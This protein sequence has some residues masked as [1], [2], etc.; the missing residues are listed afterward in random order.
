MLL[1]LPTITAVRVETLDIANASSQPTV[2][3]GTGH[4]TAVRI[5]LDE[6]V[7]YSQEDDMLP[8]I[9]THPALVQS[10]ACITDAADAAAGSFALTF[11]GETTVPIA[12]NSTAAAVR[13]A[14]EALPTITQVDV[15]YVNVAQG[16]AAGKV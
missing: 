9:Q 16:G 2:C 11:A 4:R 5:Y 10:L 1:A 15:R 13:A 6:V 3:G 14:L 8:L 12:V 7:G